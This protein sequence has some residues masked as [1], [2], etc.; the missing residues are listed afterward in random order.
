[1]RMHCNYLTHSTGDA[2][3]AV[4]AGTGYNFCLLLTGLR[5]LLLRIQLALNAPH[6]P[7]HA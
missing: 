3:N 2:V 5:L 4:V 7:Q 1:M 6:H